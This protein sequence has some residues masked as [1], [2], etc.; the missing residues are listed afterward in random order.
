MS[1]E[2]VGVVERLFDAWRREGFGV[3]TELMDPEIEYVNPSYAVEPGT[4]RGYEGFTIAAEA[5]RAVYGE[6]LLVPLELYDA[7]SKVAVRARVVARGIGSSVEVD[8]ER[9]Y[10]LDLRD[11]KVV[12]LAWFNHPAEALETVGLQE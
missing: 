8:T 2:N 9:G 1:Q 7:G 12:R 5:V 4:R 6:R 10:V 11:G 3:V